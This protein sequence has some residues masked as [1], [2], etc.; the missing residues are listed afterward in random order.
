MTEYH[1]DEH[2]DPGETFA[3]PLAGPLGDAGADPL[4][5]GGQLP[6][7]EPETAPAEAELRFPG[8]A[9]PGLDPDPPSAAWA[10]DERFERWLEGSQPAGAGDDPPTDE[11]TDEELREQLA[12]PQDGGGLASPDALVEWTLRRLEGDG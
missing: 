11:P 5:D 3:E 4:A 8:E 1:H 7:P 10:D 2:D 12:P 6:A 9:P